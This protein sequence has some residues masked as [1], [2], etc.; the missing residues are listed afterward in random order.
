MTNGFS[1]RGITLASYSFDSEIYLEG[2]AAGSCESNSRA[3][4]PP[5]SK[6]FCQVED[7]Q[8]L[9]RRLISSSHWCADCFEISL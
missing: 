7:S 9:T 2:T 1:E 5:R 3:W 6:Q 4:L 8:Q